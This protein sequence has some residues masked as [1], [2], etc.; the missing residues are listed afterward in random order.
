MTQVLDYINKLAMSFKMLEPQIKSIKTAK[1]IKA[2]TILVIIQYVLMS[3]LGN[4]CCKMIFSV[5][6]GIVYLEI[7]VSNVKITLTFNLLTK[8]SKAFRHII[9]SIYC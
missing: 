9:L 4:K 1:R 5:Y 7:L 3:T 8:L 2:L 6:I